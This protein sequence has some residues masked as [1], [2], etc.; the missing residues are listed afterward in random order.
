M[1]GFSITDRD[2][3]FQMTLNER[4][5][6]DKKVLRE[7]GENKLYIGLRKQFSKGIFGHTVHEYVEIL[8]KEILE[9]DKKSF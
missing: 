5:D 6:F 3:L 1:P 9:E 8:K 2:V 4:K 7:K